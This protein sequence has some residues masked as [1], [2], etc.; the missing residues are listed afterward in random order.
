MRDR[1]FCFRREV[2]AW[3]RKVETEWPR[4]S[5]ESVAEGVSEFCL[6]EEVLVSAKVTLNSLSPEDVAVQALTGL[7]DG[8]GNLKVPVVIPMRL[9]ERYAAEAYLFQTVVQPFARSG[10]HG[11]AIRLLPK[12]ADS[13]S[14]FLPG[15]MKWALASSPVAE[16]QAR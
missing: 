7:V 8:E 12:H 14:P 5:V 10:L 15:P 4:L 16:L 1:T 9:S 2:A 3:M 11:Y 6:G 13:I